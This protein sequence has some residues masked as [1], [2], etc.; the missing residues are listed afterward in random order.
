MPDPGN[1]GNTAVGDAKAALADAAGEPQDPGT[2][3]IV[4]GDPGLGEHNQGGNFDRVAETKRQ[5][6]AAQGYN[7]VLKRVSGV[8][9]FN[10]ALTSNGVLDG[11][12]YIGHA[13]YNALFVGEQHAAGTDIDRSNVSQLSNAKLSQNAYIKINACFAGSGG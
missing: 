13:S 9:D 8:E 7:V 10:R 5:E 1:S 4:V 3:L 6:L 11:V 12:E 2:I